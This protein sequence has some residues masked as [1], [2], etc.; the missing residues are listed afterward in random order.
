M[1]CTRKGWW[2]EG[3]NDLTKPKILSWEKKSYTTNKSVCDEIFVG[4]LMENFDSIIYHEKMELFLK[5]LADL[6]KFKSPLVNQKAFKQCGRVLLDSC[7][8]LL[9][10]SLVH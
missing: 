6:W 3:E 8:H 10:T 7:K 2:T 5:K 4:T 1:Y 9:G